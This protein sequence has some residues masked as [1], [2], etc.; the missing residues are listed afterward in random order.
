MVAICIAMVIIMCINIFFICA[1]ILSSRC[2]RE[3]EKLYATKTNKKKR[4]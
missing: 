4:K 2:E 3:S 1:I